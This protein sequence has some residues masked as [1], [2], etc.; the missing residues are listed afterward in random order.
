VAIASL[1]AGQSENVATNSQA[2]E[3]TL[4]PGA[5]LDSVA[6]DVLQFPG[7]PRFVE[8]KRSIYVREGGGSGLSLDRARLLAVDHPFGTEA[9]TVAAGGIVAGVRE[10]ATAVRESRDH[11]VTSA[12]IGS[13]VEPVYADS[14]EVLTV[15]L[16]AADSSG[17]YLLIEASD[18]GGGSGGIRVET[19]SQSPILLATV[20][21]R[22]RASAQAVQL[23]GQSTIRLRFALA[24]A[25]RFVG[26]LGS[27]QAPVVNSAALLS[28]VGAGSDW[29]SEARSLDANDV[30]I[31]AQDTLH[32]TFADAPS[33][34]TSRRDW[35]LALDGTPVSALTATYLSSRV[36]SEGLT[37]P[38]SRFALY[39]N[40]PNPFRGAT[41][42]AYDLPVACDVR[43]EIFD[44]L[45]RLVRR[46]ESH[47]A[48]GRHHLEWDLRDARGNQVA[49]G[50]YTYRF[51]G[52]AFTARRK[53]VVLL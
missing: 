39:Q 50:V 24:C 19:A 30:V 53:M 31:Q 26:R 18:G 17:D 41:T 35:F 21:P 37:S 33:A 12:A 52:A 36:H 15:S 8:G 5:P 29:S 3:N 10:P 7:E 38:P 27:A 48:P 4:F 11:D 2:S 25:L 45:G 49:P 13:S 9:V 51:T 43:L 1:T 14:G 46:F 20:H 42:I 44:L 16:P 40:V 47:E 34:A 6:T 28:A 23:T 22:S 32:L